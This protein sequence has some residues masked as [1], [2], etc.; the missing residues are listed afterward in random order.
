[1]DMTGMNM[2]SVLEEICLNLVLG[3]NI[4][5]HPPRDIEHE[6]CYGCI[7]DDERNKLCPHYKPVR[8]SIH[9]IKPYKSRV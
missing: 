7:R 8:V 2:A 4:K 3:E 5:T 6:F 1:M 9:E